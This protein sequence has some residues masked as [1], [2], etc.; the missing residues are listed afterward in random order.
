MASPNDFKPKQTSTQP[1]RSTSRSRGR[2]SPVGEA[3]AYSATD[4]SL[5]SHHVR[6]FVCAKPSSDL[7]KKSARAI[8]QLTGYNLD[9][10]LCGST[11][12]KFISKSSSHKDKPT[13]S[14]AN[15][16][17]A[18]SSDADLVLCDEACHFS[19]LT[20]PLES[21][22]TSLT[23]YDS[24]DVKFISLEAGEASIQNREATRVKK[25]VPA[26]LHIQNQDSGVCPETL[27]EKQAIWDIFSSYLPQPHPS[28]GSSKH[29]RVATAIALLEVQDDA[30]IFT[31]DIKTL[32][33][34]LS[35][36]SPK[37]AIH[38]NVSQNQ[39]ISRPIIFQEDEIEIIT[40][41]LDPENTGRVSF[42]S[43]WR[44]WVFGLEV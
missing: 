29:S 24:P 5:Y 18:F 39:S 2:Q 37:A 19:D 30:S 31:T 13:T 23:T 12:D 21:S 6:N 9:P 38:S 34:V 16:V 20:F 28:P 33:H 25:K 44:L 43:F 22:S 26:S 35:H 14:K 1:I 36:K 32:L 40:N 10:V 41:E 4:I 15:R 42:A 3:K 8:F 7:A 11:K 27:D 17:N